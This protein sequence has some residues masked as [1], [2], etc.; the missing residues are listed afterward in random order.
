MRALLAASVFGSVVGCSSQA[1]LER[2]ACTDAFFVDVPRVAECGSAGPVGGSC[3]ERRLLGIALASAGLAPMGHKPG[4]VRIALLNQTQDLLLVFSVL[5][6]EEGQFVCYVVKIGGD[7]SL[8]DE[9][10]FGTGTRVV[11]QPSLK[12]LAMLQTLAARTGAA[13]CEQARVSSSSP[14]STGRALVLVEAVNSSGQYTRLITNRPLS[15]IVGG[16]E[17]ANVLASVY[18]KAGYANAPSG[19]TWLN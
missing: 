4:E 16:A 2:P 8:A 19:T 18:A 12:S 1:P 17:V 13:D 11:R 14:E 5:A 10:N 9:R 3:E 6:C 15:G 7:K